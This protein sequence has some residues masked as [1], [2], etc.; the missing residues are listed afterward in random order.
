MKE[1]D[2]DI[3]GQFSKYLDRFENAPFDVIITLCGNVDAQCPTWV[4]EQK[5]VHIGFLDP[6]SA[7]GSEKEVLQIFR[8]VR[9][10][11]RREVLGYFSKLDAETR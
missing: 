4:G 2:I 1:I 3:S 8:M 9:D 5:K 10:D 6:A 7:A 11:I